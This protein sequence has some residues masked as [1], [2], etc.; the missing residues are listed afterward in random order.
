MRSDRNSCV[1][2]RTV[3]NG[4]SNLKNFG[5]LYDGERC[6]LAPLFDQVTTTIYA[7]ER[8]GGGRSTDRTM[9]LRLRK[10]RDARSRSYP[11]REALVAFGREV[12]GVE[13]PERDIE[14]NCRA[15]EVTLEAARR[16]ARIPKETR[17]GLVNEW[18]GAIRTLG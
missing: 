9:A 16:D 6:W 10:G 17:T 5:V 14:E 13:E 2:L 7:V 11:G 18:L 15:M 1:T 12:C 4:D 3:T 8:A